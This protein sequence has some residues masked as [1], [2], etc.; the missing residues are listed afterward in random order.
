MADLSRYEIHTD[1]KYQSL[2]PFDVAAFAKQHEPWFNQ[3]LVKVNE[4]VVRL[5]ILEGDFHWHKHE[6]EDEFFFVL[7][8]RLHIDVEGRDSVTLEPHHGFTVPR[9]VMHRPRAEGRTVVLMVEP[10]EVVPTGD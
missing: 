6:R 3:T 1:V 7:E 4:S 10:V 2:V 5:G 9:N 8:G